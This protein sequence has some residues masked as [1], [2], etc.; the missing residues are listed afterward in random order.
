MVDCKDGG[1]KVPFEFARRK[2]VGN[3]D[4]ATWKQI[5][6][7]CP[8]PTRADQL[9]LARFLPL[10]SSDSEEAPEN[11]CPVPP[12]SFLLSASS[13]ESQIIRL[14]GTRLL[15][16]IQIGPTYEA[17]FTPEGVVSPGIVVHAHAVHF[18][19]HRYFYILFSGP[20]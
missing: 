9:A 17:C 11:F 3:V 12:T 10:C 6:T 8:W 18:S 16:A 5:I 15:V 14:I 2:L 7:L 20:G 19:T 1:D 13:Q 4:D